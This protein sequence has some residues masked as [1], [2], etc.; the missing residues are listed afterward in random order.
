MFLETLCGVELLVNIFVVDVGRQRVRLAETLDMRQTPQSM[1]L[2]V[3]GRQRVRLAETLDMRQTPQSMR[4]LVVS[5]AV[6]VTFTALE[7]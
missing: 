2:V 4:L 5:N 3:V 7:S 6:E 1:R